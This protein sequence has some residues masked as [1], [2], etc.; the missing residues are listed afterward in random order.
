[1]ISLLWQG[2][3]TGLLYSIAAMGLVM[4]F[5]SSKMVNFAHG[6]IAGLSAFVVYAVTTGTLGWPWLAGVLVALGVAVAV[7]SIAYLAIAP[8][9]ND[10]DTLKDTATT[11]TIATLGFG[12]MMEG[13]I[14]WLFGSNIVSLDL[15]LPNWSARLMG[16]RITSYD[17]AVLAVTALVVCGLFLLIDRTRLGI[18]FRAVSSRPF[19]AAVC[20][21][22][23]RKVHLFSWIVSAILGVVAALLIV[24]TTFLSSTTVATFMLQA[25]AAAVI[26]GFESLPGSV[27]GGILV[28][29][30]SNLFT[31]YVAP[32]FINSFLLALILMSLSFFPGGILS[33]RV[34]ARV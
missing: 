11:A 2:T 25:F 33:R 32:E 26:G 4:I 1:M 10:T 15:P 7:A 34:G 16:V 28:G 5:K 18:A 8:L 9:L 14:L 23:V 20:G 13:L 6:S 12:L 17:I 22:S 27:V 29:I 21:L 31:F 24:P 19:A 30:A 3:V